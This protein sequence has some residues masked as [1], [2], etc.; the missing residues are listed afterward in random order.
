MVTNQ[1]NFYVTNEMPIPALNMH[2]LV[3]TGTI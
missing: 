3:A 2:D 1:K